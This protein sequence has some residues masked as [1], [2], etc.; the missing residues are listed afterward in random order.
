L[1]VPRARNLICRAEV[2]PQLN[3]WLDQ[4]AARLTG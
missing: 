1:M 3:G 2:E 4:R